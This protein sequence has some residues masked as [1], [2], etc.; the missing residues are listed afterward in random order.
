M[1]IVDVNKDL[2]F[3]SGFLDLQSIKDYEAT[4]A[5]ELIFFN[6]LTD[7]LITS[8]TRVEVA[9]SGKTMMF[10]AELYR[11][12]PKTPIFDHSNYRLFERIPAVPGTSNNQG[13]TVLYTETV[14]DQTDQFVD[15]F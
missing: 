14:V 3:F 8:R 10:Y 13:L 11:I 4:T 12:Y 15:V 1:Y 5:K 2:I 9:N 7:A 6:A